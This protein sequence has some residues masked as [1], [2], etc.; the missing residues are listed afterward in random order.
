MD[1]GYLDAIFLANIL[2]NIFTIFLFCLFVILPLILAILGYVKSWGIKKTLGRYILSILCII[3]LLLTIFIVI[4]MT[5]PTAEENRAKFQEKVKQERIRLLDITDN[6]DKY[7]DLPC[8]EFSLNENRNHFCLNRSRVPRILKL[9]GKAGAPKGSPVH[10]AVLHFISKTHKKDKENLRHILR[11]NI[12]DYE[13]DITLPYSYSRFRDYR[14]EDKEKKKL[15]IRKHN[16]MINNPK[17]N[18]KFIDIT[19]LENNG[20]KHDVYIYIKDK[21]VSA[22]FKIYANEVFNL[23]GDIY[24]QTEETPFYY[25]FHYLSNDDITKEQFLR[26]IL[27]MAE[28]FDEFFKAS[29][30]QKVNKDLLNN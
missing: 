17:N 1:N 7:K 10:S 12:E 29:Q 21:K 27:S 16:Q 19:K 4:G 8:F 26:R 13:Y 9:Y 14:S 24:Y 30:V 22:Y 20:F 15:A 2:K 3:G 18:N 5:A 28:E 6:P 25:H 11:V 23:I